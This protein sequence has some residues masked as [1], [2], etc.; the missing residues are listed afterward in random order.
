MARLPASQD[1]WESQPSTQPSSSSRR[2]ENASSTR[3]RTGQLTARS[4]VSVP[5]M[6][7]AGR[8]DPRWQAGGW[9]RRHTIIRGRRR[10]R[11]KRYPR[12]RTAYR[13]RQREAW[14]QSSSSEEDSQ[15][16]LL[17]RGLASVAAAEAA[18]TVSSGPTDVPAAASIR[19]GGEAVMA[20][21]GQTDFAKPTLASLFCDRVWPKPT[22]AKTPKPTLA[23]TDFGQ[24][25]FGENEF[26]LLCVVCVAWV[27]FHGIKVGFHVW[28]LVRPSWD[29]PS[30]DRPSPGPPF[31][32]TALP[33]TAL[34]L[35]RP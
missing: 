19:G 2:H 1:R 28:V 13:W 32:W 17:R 25:D 4:P 20:D 12:R 33:R 18:G 22:L 35:D 26:D 21:F 16:R 11:T 23:K 27:L 30:W 31:P 34:P 15:P 3:S 6:S 7:E 29:R 10:L 5:P 24:S 14:Q 9:R 8:L